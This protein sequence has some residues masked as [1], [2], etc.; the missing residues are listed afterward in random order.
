MNLSAFISHL[1]REGQVT[2]A[3]TIHPFSTQ[4]IQD[5]ATVLHQYY[6]NDILDMPGTA[7]AFDE[8]AAMWAAIYIYRAVQLAMLRQLGEEQIKILLTPYPDAITPEAIYGAD[9]CLRYLPDLV[10]LSKGLSPDDPLVQHL[11]ETAAVWPFS[12]TGMNIP[13][14]AV[15]DHILAHPSLL[16]AY[17][18]RIIASRDTDRCRI[19]AVKEAVKASLGNYT[20]ILW[21][22]FKQF[23]SDTNQYL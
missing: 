5:T 3:D 8:K 2:V 17:A 21:P 15:L 20:D 16:Q 19:P 4:E 22:D 13:V 7:P 10:S 12:S 11:K 6:E 1:I 9:L 23:I 18:D 14:T